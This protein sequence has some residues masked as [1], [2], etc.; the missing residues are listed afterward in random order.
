MSGD[1][2]FEDID[3]YLATF[4]KEN[5]ETPSG[6][7]NVWLNQKDRTLKSKAELQIQGNLVLFLKY[8]IGASGSKIDW[9]FA[10]VAGRGDVRIIRK[11]D[12]P[13]TPFE[14]CILELKVLREYRSAEFN[15]KWALKGIR[16]ALRYTNA[17][18]GAKLAYLCCFDAR[19]TDETIEEVEIEAAKNSIRSRRYYMSN[20]S[21][22]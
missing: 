16:Q 20:T 22:P 2:S 9:E 18:Q 5:T 12:E 11:T 7:C 13:D 14:G 8:T 4:H 1:V 10:T 21:I 15:K 3:S 19:A 6:L 17:D